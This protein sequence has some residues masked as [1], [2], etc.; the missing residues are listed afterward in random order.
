MKLL[1]IEEWTTETDHL[2]QDLHA[3]TG[4]AIEHAKS[5]DEALFKLLQN[6]GRIDLITL[7]AGGRA[8]DVLGFPERVRT[9]TANNLI[10]CPEMV[11]LAATMLPLPCA[12]KLLDQQVIC[13][14]RS[15]EKSITEMIRILLW[16]L[17]SARSGLVIRIE[18]RGGNYRFFICG[19]GCS[20]EIELSTQI[21]RLLRLLLREFNSYTVEML[22]D[23]LGISRQS[24]K[25][26][27]RELRAAIAIAMTKI[28]SPAAPEIVWMRRLPGGTLCG[29]R[30]H[31]IWS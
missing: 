3:G 25:K 6:G 31:P 16:R 1:H 8:D 12:A 28:K 14:L 29:I 18:F 26:Y 23:E 19:T 9:L 24:V 22:A 4:C 11:V 15:S 20:Q 21:G 17:R 7:T 2:I 10:R 13:L 30:A 27:M 5:I